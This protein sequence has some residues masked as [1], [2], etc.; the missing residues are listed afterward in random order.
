MLTFHSVG[1][2]RHNFTASKYNAK[3]ATVR[4]TWEASW[5]L[6]SGPSCWRSSFTPLDCYSQAQFKVKTCTKYHA[7]DATMRL[8]SKLL[9]RTLSY[10]A[11]GIWL[12]VCRR[13]ALSNSTQCWHNL[14]GV[15]RSCWNTE[16]ENNELEDHEPNDTWSFLLFIM[17]TLISSIL[18]YSILF[19]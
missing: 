6:E 3:E 13:H 10:L 14:A 15:S 8:T 5:P 16:H 1:L 2:L 19:Y 11:P 9:D 17:L 18:F 7:Q 12:H 4:L